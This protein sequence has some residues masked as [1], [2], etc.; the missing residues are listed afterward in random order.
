MLDMIP[1]DL[2]S[3]SE[4][5]TPIEYEM[6]PEQGSLY[7][8]QPRKPRLAPLGSPGPVTPLALEP[9]SERNDYL[10]TTTAAATSCAEESR[11]GTTQ[12]TYSLSRDELTSMLKNQMRPILSQ[13]VSQDD[14]II[15]MKTKGNRRRASSMEQAN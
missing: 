6:L 10:S 8:S 11:N 7:L 3:S 14:S 4:D 5:V 1:S 2:D 15:G 9:V 12:L 13:K